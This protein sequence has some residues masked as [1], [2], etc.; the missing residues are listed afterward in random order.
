MPEIIR[1]LYKTSAAAPMLCLSQGHL[2]RLKD[3]QGGPLIEGKHWFSGPT[4]NSPIR[5]DVPEILKLL[6]HRGQARRLADRELLAAG[7]APSKLQE[8]G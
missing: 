6:S 7:M 3:S 5:W 2:Q 8:V 1:Q 4:P